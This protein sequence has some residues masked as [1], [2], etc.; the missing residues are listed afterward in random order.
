MF[1]PRDVGMVQYTEIHQLNP[2][3]N[4]TQRKKPNHMIISLDTE[5]AFDKIQYPSWKSLGNI[6][7]SRSIHVNNKSNIQ[8]ISS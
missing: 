6:R 2:L 3:Y 8:Q 5:K 1:H 7:N 4:Q